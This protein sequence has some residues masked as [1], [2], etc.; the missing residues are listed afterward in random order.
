MKRVIIYSALLLAILATVAGVLYHFG[1]EVSSEQYPHGSSI[2]PKSGSENDSQ[3]EPIEGAEDYPPRF[4]FTKIEGKLYYSKRIGENWF[5]IGPR[6]K[7]PAPGEVARILVEGENVFY[8]CEEELAE[9]RVRLIVLKNGEEIARYEDFLLIHNFGVCL[10]KPVFWH[11]EGIYWDK[12]FYRFSALAEEISFLCTPEYFIYIEW[13]DEEKK[14]SVFLNGELHHTFRNEDPDKCDPVNI[15]H[16]TD[17]ARPFVFKVGDDIY[18]EG[19][20][21][22]KD[23]IFKN[24][25]IVANL[26]GSFGHVYVYDEDEFVLT[27]V[28]RDD[29]GYYLRNDTI[30]G[31]FNH[32]AWYTLVSR[33]GRIYLALQNDDGGAYRI[34]AFEK[35]LAE[36]VVWEFDEPFAPYRIF[37]T[38]EDIFAYGYDREARKECI[39]SYQDQ[40]A[41]LI[42]HWWTSSVEGEYEDKI[43]TVFYCTDRFYYIEDKALF[44]VIKAGI[45]VSEEQ[46]TVNPAINF[47]GARGV[48]HF[49]A[50]D[51][52]TF[53]GWKQDKPYL[54][55]GDRIIDLKEE[56]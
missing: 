2:L 14:S 19:Y 47:V 20:W 53:I 3:Y 6:L 25:E 32:I 28:S 46:W 30:F 35:G 1:K 38:D 9:D 51:E 43:E 42:A 41:H 21:D 40:K 55:S 24:G 33:S 12:T 13:S 48:H 37:V 11:S 27:F 39:I 7:Y 22:G 16:Q 36:E 10:G 8:F 29:Q 49:E 18:T 34:L 52:L 31:P 56:E 23:T 17:W 54:V 26:P 44:K 50:G 45:V 15:N 5:V 4:T